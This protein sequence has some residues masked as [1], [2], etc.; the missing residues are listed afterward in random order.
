MARQLGLNRTF[1][2]AVLTILIITFSAILLIPGASSVDNSEIPVPTTPL[3]RATN[4]TLIE[5][6]ILAPVSWTKAGSPYIIEKEIYHFGNISLDIEPGVEII[7]RENGTLLTDGVINAFG[8]PEERITFR[9][10]DMNEGVYQV[11]GLTEWPTINL[12]YCDF[13]DM[14]PIRI[15]GTDNFDFYRCNFYGTSNIVIDNASCGCPFSTVKNVVFTENNFYDCPQAFRMRND[16]AWDLPNYIYKNNF[17][18]SSVV[19]KT[20]FQN[21]SRA[22]FSIWHNSEGFGNYWDDYDGEDLDG[23]G[24]GDTNLPWADV[25]WHPLMR[26]YDFDSDNDGFPDIEDID[27]DNDGY[28]DV[29]EAKAGTDWFNKSSVPHIPKWSDDLPDIELIPGTEEVS[30]DLADYASDEDESDTLSFKLIDYFK[31]SI[32][33]TIRGSKLNVKYV[34]DANSAIWV[35]VTDNAF[36]VDTNISVK[37]E[38]SGVVVE[39][40]DSDVDGLLDEWEEENFG[41]LDQGPEDDFDLDGLSNLKEHEG[42]TNPTISDITETSDND[43]D[44]LLDTWEIQYFSTLEYGPTDDNDGDGITNLVE[45]TGGTDPTIKDTSEEDDG[46]DS[47]DGGISNTAMALGIAAI[48]IVLVIVVAIIIYLVIFKNRPE[49]EEEGV[50]REAPWEKAAEEEAKKVVPTPPPQLE[51]QAAPTQVVEQKPPT[52]AKAEDKTEAE[53]AKDEPPKEDEGVAEEDG[54]KEEDVIEDDDLEIPDV[55]ELFID[56]EDLEIPSPD[57]L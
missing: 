9:C 44:G 26:E 22:S 41:G 25:D 31:E 19:F 43:E 47:D 32:K 23:D 24:T 6:D 17:Y 37:A 20:F 11:L 8:T 46:G 56:D 38:I 14:D 12:D 13:I 4:G 49:E 52:A 15:I 27:D 18:N 1:L 21:G 34:G 53:E 33:V 3:A 30:I 10:E 36:N 5:K 57:E 50:V 2:S 45:H 29:S 48:A 55:D 16:S 51:V 39:D 42:G 35:R 7:F 54:T 40:P 28:M